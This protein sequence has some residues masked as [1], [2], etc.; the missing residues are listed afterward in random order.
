MLF[1]HSRVQL[2]RRFG[3]SKDFDLLDKL[4]DSLRTRVTRSDDDKRESFLNK[5]KNTISE[6]I[7]PQQLF[8][9]SEP[10]EEVFTAK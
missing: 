4:L 5:L 6:N 10:F 1:F 3:S 7:K 9:P 8:H 2:N